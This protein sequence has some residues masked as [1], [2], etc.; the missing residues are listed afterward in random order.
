MVGRS[1]VCPKALC[2]I[3]E[4][5]SIVTFLLTLHKVGECLSY[6]FWPEWVIILVLLGIGQRC[7]N[8]LA[9]YL[10]YCTSVV[11]WESLTL[12][13]HK[14]VNEM[15]TSAQYLMFWL[16][17]LFPDNQMFHLQIP[18]KYMHSRG[19][20]LLW[21]GIFPHRLVRKKTHDHVSIEKVEILIVG[22]GRTIFMECHQ[23][24]MVC[25]NLYSWE[26]QHMPY[27]VHKVGF[28]HSLWWYSTEVPAFLKTFL[29]LS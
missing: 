24:M 22:I 1:I 13:Q 14:T 17:W 11:S 21:C 15:L 28:L 26:G 18:I 23:L 5:S 19:I 8:V 4:D 20:A 29:T 12:H 7:T 6:C 9:G 2:T 16:F 3:A 25:R 27:A 10:Y